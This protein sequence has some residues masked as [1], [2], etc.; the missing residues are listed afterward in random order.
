MS[1]DR[2]VRADNPHLRLSILQGGHP[3]PAE[4]YISLEE[5]H[6]RQPTRHTAADLE[7]IAGR[8]DPDDPAVFQLS[9]GDDRRPETDPPHA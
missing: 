3:E 1:C 5:L 9:G 7:R 6:E 8:I 2:R 4:G